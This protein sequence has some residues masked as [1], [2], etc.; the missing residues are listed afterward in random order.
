MEKRKVTLKPGRQSCGTSWSQK[1]IEEDK[2]KGETKSIRKK[3]KEE[4]HQRLREKNDRKTYKPNL[5]A[6]KNDNS[7]IESYFKTDRRSDSS[8]TRSTI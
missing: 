1:N 2:R 8:I 6:Q 3:R 5:P 7:T 4:K